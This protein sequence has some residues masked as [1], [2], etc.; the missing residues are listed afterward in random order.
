MDFDNFIKQLNSAI[1]PSEH[2]T[3]PVTSLNAVSPVVSSN[4]SESVPTKSTKKLKILIVSTHINQINGYSK[5]IMNIIQQLGTQ[6][7]IDVVHFGSQRINGGDLGRQYPKNVKVIDASA[8]EKQKGLGFA[9][10]ELPNVIN[11][12]KPD[13]VFIYND[14]AIISSYIEEIRKA[15]QNRFFKIWAYLDLTHVG[16]PQNVFDVINR[17]VERVFCFNK[18]WKNELKNNGITRPVDVMTHGVDPKVFRTIPRELA[19]QS[20]GLPRDILLFTSMNKNIPRKRLDL[21]IMSFVKLIVRFPTK[22]IFLLIVADKGDKGGFNLFEIFARELKLA[23]ATTEAFGN[24]LLITSKDAAY[25]DEDINL[26]YNCGDVGI[27]CAEAEGFGLCT[28]E[29]MSVGVPQIVPNIAAYKE[30]CNEDNS[31]MVE[32]KMRYYIP[33]AYTTVT[34]EAHLVDPED[35]AKAMEK[36]VFDEDLRKL[37]SKLGKEKV[38]G[39]NYSWEKCCATFIKRLNTIKEEI[40][41]DD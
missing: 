2:S 5:V 37:H 12:E 28:F 22:P 32:P 4:A 3:V 11:A 7:W 30:Y 40:E 19:R 36:Y 39:G 18:F 23:G 33:Q 26:L 35:V 34:G 6:E 24:R 41:E 25:R 14:M 29:Q 1:A 13:I 8:L 10:S 21:V 9:F 15:I 38:G 31:I 20:L 17:D 27:S 16:F